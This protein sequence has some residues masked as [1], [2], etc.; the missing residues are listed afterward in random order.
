M[1]ITNDG[2]AVTGLF[3]SGNSRDLYF[4]RGGRLMR[5]SADG[6]TPQPA[7]ATSP[8]SNLVVSPDGTR[9]AYVK[10]DAGATR[11]EILSW[12]TAI[13]WSRHLMAA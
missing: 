8:V 2:S 1:A 13:N 11:S 3:W 5:I 6:G 12:M 7:F 4:T 9:A 10:K